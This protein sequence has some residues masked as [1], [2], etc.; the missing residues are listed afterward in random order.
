M[1][2][3]FETHC[4]D[5]VI[6]EEDRRIYGTVRRELNWG[7]TPAL[8]AIDL[9]N[10]AY[11][12]GDAPVAEINDTFAASCGEYAWKTIDP[13]KRLLA[14]AR[15]VGIPVIYSTGVSDRAPSSPK[16]YVTNR[17]RTADDH[18]N[19]VYGIFEPFKP[20]EDDLIVYKERASAFFGTPLLAYLKQM[21]IDSL[22]A[23][24]ETTSCCVRSTVA[25]AFTNGYHVTLVEE[26]CFD[27]SQLLH[28]VNLFDMH[29]KF[30]DVV[31]VEQAL[32]HL[33]ERANVQAA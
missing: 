21:G 26:C 8:L 24:G 20:A 18:H 30:A 19:D 4:W 6:G 33:G 28:K 14:A 15:K 3:D 29:H 12:G 25:D 2:Q 23:C 22:I 16:I 27:R 9:Y 31:H 13:T 1:A 11:A 17:L 5:D 32:A 7:K 10:K